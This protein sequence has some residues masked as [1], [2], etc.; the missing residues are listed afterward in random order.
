MKGIF[1]GVLDIKLWLKPIPIDDKL[2]DD[3]D[4][5]VVV[6]VT[7]EDTPGEN[8]E[9]L[10]QPKVAVLGT[11]VVTHNTSQLLYT[12]WFQ[13]QLRHKGIFQ[14]TCRINIFIY[15]NLLLM[16]PS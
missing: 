14:V 9:I 3:E 12:I 5:V 16:T 7:V 6:E 2:E 15:A 4:T 8:A 10:E 1:E 13:T 11:T